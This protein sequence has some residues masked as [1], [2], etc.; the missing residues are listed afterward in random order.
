MMLDPRSG[1]CTPR[2][3]APNERT[4]GNPTTSFSLFGHLEDD[5]TPFMGRQF[6]QH[7]LS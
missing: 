5:R 7:K 3:L 2:P 6:S 4:S 1:C